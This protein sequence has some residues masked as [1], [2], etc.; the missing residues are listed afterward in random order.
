M[1]CFNK[2]VLIITCIY[3]TSSAQLNGKLT[4]ISLNTGLSHSSVSKIIQDSTGFY[5][6][7]VAESVT[8]PDQEPIKFHNELSRDGP[9]LL[10]TV[11]A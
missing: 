4:K 2:I 5:R 7:P 9:W 3:S 1:S 8:I 11:F 10:I 6:M